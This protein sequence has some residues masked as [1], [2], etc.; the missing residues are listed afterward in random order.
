MPLTALQKKHG[1]EEK[2]QMKASIREAGRKW[3]EKQKAKAAK[4][5]R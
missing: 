1:E 3:R 4:K 5:Q 2:K